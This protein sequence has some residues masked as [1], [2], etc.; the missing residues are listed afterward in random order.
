MFL[1][2]VLK[3]PRNHNSNYSGSF[4]AAAFD[5]NMVVNTLVGDSFVRRKLRVTVSQ[6]HWFI[7]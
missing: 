7:F 4:A 2:V 3:R 1:S 6:F 5:W